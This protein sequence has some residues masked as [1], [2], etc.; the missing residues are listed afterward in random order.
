VYNLHAALEDYSHPVSASLFLAYIVN[1]HTIALN[2]HPHKLHFVASLDLLHIRRGMI[3]RRGS[4][5]MKS[6]AQREGAA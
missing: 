2:R 6:D 1:T 4:G 3:C 5:A